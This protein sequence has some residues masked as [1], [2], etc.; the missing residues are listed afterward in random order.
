MKTDDPFYIVDLSYFVKRYLQWFHYLPRIQPYYAIKCNPNEFIIKTLAHQGIGFDCASAGELDLVLS[1]CPNIDCEKQI[2]YSHPCKPISHIKYFRQHHV[3]MTVVDNEDELF[4]I[5]EYW[6]NAKVLLRLKI[7]KNGNSMSTK[8]GANQYQILKLL[9]LAKQLNINLVGCSFHVGSQC[10]DRNLYEETLQFARKIFD[11][12]QREE[13]GGFKFTVLDIGGGFPVQFSQVAEMIRDMIDKLFPE[14]EG[15]KMDHFT[16][17]S[18]FLF[19][20]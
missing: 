15:K 7:I 8:F 14:E 12:A 10:S 16:I 11:L 3:Q 1:T 18:L 6:S 4:K 13:Y 2:I 19:Y 9:K 5:K 17:Y 20:S